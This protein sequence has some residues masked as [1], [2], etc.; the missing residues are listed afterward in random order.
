VDRCSRS[1]VVPEQP[2]GARTCENLFG[3]GEHKDRFGIF[4]ICENLE[5]FG[6]NP[7]VKD[8][9]VPPSSSARIFMTRL[10]VDAAIA[11]LDEPRAD[12]DTVMAARIITRL[13]D[14]V[15]GMPLDNLTVRQ[16]RRAVERFQAPERWSAL[17]DGALMALKE[18]IADRPTTRVD[19]GANAKRF[20]L[21]ILKTQVALLRSLPSLSKLRQKLVAVAVEFAKLT[22]VP[23]MQ[24]QI[25]LIEVIQTEAFW[26]GVYALI[27]DDVRLALRDLVKLSESK[28]QKAVITD[29]EDDVGGPTLTQIGPDGPSVDKGRFKQNVRETATARGLSGPRFTSS[30]WNAPRSTREHSVAARRHR[31]EREA[32]P[33]RRHTDGA[34]SIGPRD[35]VRPARRRP[36]RAGRR[37]AGR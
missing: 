15:A 16:R 2:R 35:R 28:R 6:Q 36:P 26:D 29:F 1:P 34:V 21:L 8:P 31:A 19:P 27:L 12:D 11:G 30:L 4:D 18:E 14:D 33:D 37:L 20:D 10:D 24:R 25:A 23:D 7:D 5:F 9:R 17:D 3:P 13:R 22:A 32:R